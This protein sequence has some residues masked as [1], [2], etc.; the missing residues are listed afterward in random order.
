MKNPRLKLIERL[1]KKLDKFEVLISEEKNKKQLEEKVLNYLIEIEEQIHIILWDK[2]ERTSKQEEQLFK[3][4]ISMYNL[5]SDFEEMDYY[6]DKLSYVLYSW[7]EEKTQELR[8]DIFKKWTIQIVRWK[9]KWEKKEFSKAEK[10]KMFLRVLYDLWIE[11]DEVER[12]KESLDPDRMRKLPYFIYHIKTKDLEKT[13]LICD[14]IWQATFVYDWIIDPEKFQEI[15]KWETIWN[16]RSHRIIYNSNTYISNLKYALDK[17][18]SYEEIEE[19]IIN[20]EEEKADEVKK[21]ISSEE[22]YRDLKFEDF[23]KDL[24]WFKI[25]K[26]TSKEKLNNGL[27]CYNIYSW[28]MNY[29]LD[30]KEWWE[31]QTYFVIMCSILERVKNRELASFDEVNEEFEK[32]R[33]VQDKETDEKINSEEYYRDLE[34]EDFVKDLQWFEKINTESKEKLE[35]GLS[36]YTISHWYMNYML[37]IKDNLERGDYFSIMCS[38]LERL[39]KWDFASFDEVNEEFEKE[40]ANKINSE[41]YYRDLKF[42][43]FVKDLQW[44][45][46][47][48]TTSKEKLENGLSCT[49]I[50]HWYMNYMLDI[51]EPSEKVSYFSI[52]CTI[53]E[54]AKNREFTSFYEVNE[55]F[56]KER[57]IKDKEKAKKV[58]SKKYYRDL[59]FEDFVKDL[60]WFKK[61]NTTSKEKLENGLSCYAISHWYMNYMLDIR[62]SERGSYFWIMCTIL[63]RVK[64]RELTSF[65]EVN[66]EFEKERIIKDKEK[67]EK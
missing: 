9:E 36:C 29:K 24:Q 17:N 59:K 49:Q 53:L 14:E 60:Q 63:E 43:D 25:I 51:K 44:F 46:K 18:A 38:I 13:I 65:K 41:E 1:N 37:D 40:K 12:K 67:S 4:Y 22:Y 23:V 64:N 3:R 57:E 11:E 42:E 27:W 31:R 66:R 5:D 30:I 28:Y 35:N 50:S 15:E 58:S 45:K 48:N 47:I 6:I 52:M 39:K 20:E 19:K 56:E 32:E 16:S 8:Y 21:K 10:N 61:I 62:D 2:K 55:E 54:R 33:K 26:K 34:F 7:I